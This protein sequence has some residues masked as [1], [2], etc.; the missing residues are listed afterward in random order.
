MAS[1]HREWAASA[2]TELR[3]QVVPVISLDLFFAERS[4]KPDLIK[5]DVE[6]HEREVV[7]SLRAIAQQSHPD[8]IIELLGD[9]RESSLV[10]DLECEYGYATYYISNLALHRVDATRPLPYVPGYYNFLFTRRPLDEL[11]QRLPIP[12]EA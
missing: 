3:E 2:H 1:L 5:I 9:V 6:Q 7:A 8:L 10:N 4:V 11:R 12:V